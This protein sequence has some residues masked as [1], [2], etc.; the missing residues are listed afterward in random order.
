M[1]PLSAPLI[2]A[3]VLAFLMPI[4]AQL[5]PSPSPSPSPGAEA[6]ELDSAEAAVDLDRATTLLSGYHGIPEASVFETQLTDPLGT[7][8]FIARSADSS[9]IHR[10]RALGALAYFPDGE[11]LT[12]YTSLLSDPETPELVQHRVLGHLALAYGDAAIPFADGFLASEDVQFRLTAIQVLSE[13]RS[14]EAAA[15]LDAAALDESSDVVLER[16]EAARRLR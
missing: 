15:R 14:P 2:S 7:L 12:L 13:L 1:I 9:P 5:S 11:V 10:D 16:I 3:A 8:L 6:P 4:H